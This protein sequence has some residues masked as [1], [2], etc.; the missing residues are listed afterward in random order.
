MQMHMSIWVD[1]PMKMLLPR[2]A[3]GHA[4]LSVC[5]SSEFLQ[6]LLELT[7][8]TLLRGKG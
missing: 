7:K 6:L 4:K 8:F 1:L 2:N 5:R 3:E